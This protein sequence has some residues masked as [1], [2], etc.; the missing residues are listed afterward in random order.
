M[1]VVLGGSIIAASL[2]LW[3]QQYYTSLS[4][5]FRFEPAPSSISAVAAFA[6]VFATP[7]RATSVGCFPLQP[8]SQLRLDGRRH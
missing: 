6:C 8:F 2:Y 1:L 4:D 5:A 3:Q 7:D